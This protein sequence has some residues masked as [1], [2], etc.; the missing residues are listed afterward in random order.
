MLDS[1]QFRMDAVKKFMVDGVVEVLDDLERGEFA[2][3]LKSAVEEPVAAPAG[4]AGP[5]ARG[6][7]G[8]MLG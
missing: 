5:A 6:M 4:P 1:I 3:K 7:L 2:R 8:R